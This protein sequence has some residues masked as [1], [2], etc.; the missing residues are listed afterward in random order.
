LI[1]DYEKLYN[2]YSEIYTK[3]VSEDAAAAGEAWSSGF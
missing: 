3:V 1:T 2:G